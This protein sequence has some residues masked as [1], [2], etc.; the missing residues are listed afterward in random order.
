VRVRDWCDARNR[1]LVG[2][3]APPAAGTVTTD[4]AHVSGRVWM[5]WMVAAV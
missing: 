3:P 1:G 4:G 2:E 5:R